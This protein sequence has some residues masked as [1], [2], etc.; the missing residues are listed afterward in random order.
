MTLL[1]LA[2]CT[3]LHRYCAYT[4]DG[5][6][7]TTAIYTLY[8]THWKSCDRRWREGKKFEVGRLIIPLYTGYIRHRLLRFVTGFSLP[9]KYNT[10]STRCDTIKYFL[11]T[12]CNIFSPPFVYIYSSP[13]LLFLFIL[14]PTFCFYLFFS[15]PFISIYSSPTL[16]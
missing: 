4:L 3:K 8:Y 10:F 14:L 7:I 15:P 12:F 13:H 16:L 6:L 9:Y 2:N 1:H 11:P 5:T